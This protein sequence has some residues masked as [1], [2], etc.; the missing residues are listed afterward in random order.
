MD[1]S[2]SPSRRGVS[3]PPAGWRWPIGEERCYRLQTAL[4]LFAPYNSPCEWCPAIVSVGVEGRIRHPTSLL[5]VICVCLCSRVTSAIHRGCL[6]AGLPA[7]AVSAKTLAWAILILPSISTMGVLDP[8]MASLRV[9]FHL[10][11]PP[12][13][14]AWPSGHSARHAGDVTICAPGW[15]TGKGVGGNT[16]HSQILSGRGASSCML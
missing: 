13:P 8:T 4:C 16:E 6:V 7:A 12:Q 5:Q 9:A 10:V 2:C 15:T 1:V 3:P 14:W 11:A